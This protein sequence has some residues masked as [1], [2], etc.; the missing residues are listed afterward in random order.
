VGDRIKECRFKPAAHGVDMTVAEY[1]KP[2]GGKDAAFREKVRKESS[3]DTD[4][5][6]A[7]MENWPIM[8]SNLVD[9]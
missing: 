4:S 3:T 2:N 7:S 9:I 6:K 8:V 5:S 1:V